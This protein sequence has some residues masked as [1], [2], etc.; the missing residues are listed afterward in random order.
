[1]TDQ[2]G[3]GKG[4]QPTGATGREAREH[5]RAPIELKVEYKKLNTFFSDY[6]K[7]I[8][9]GGTFIKTEKPLKVGTE[10]V[11]KLF[12]PAQDEPFT[13]RGQVA[14]T[15]TEAEAQRPEIP[16]RGMGIRFLY[17]DDAQKRGFEDF[18]EDMMKDALGDV[19]YR[20]LIDKAK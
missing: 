15:N 19:V 5:P 20:K 7:N 11:F 9:K 18:V 16:E 6:T 3:A 13:L 12:V 4:A 10:F 2:S 1:M 14:W 8:S 17:K